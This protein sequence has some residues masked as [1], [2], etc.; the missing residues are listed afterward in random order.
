MNV[1]QQGEIAGNDGGRFCNFE[2]IDGKSANYPSLQGI[3]EVFPLFYSS[4]V[5]Q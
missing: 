1:E 4:N 3:F 2:K 5:G